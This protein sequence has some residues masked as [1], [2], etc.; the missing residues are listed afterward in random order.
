MNTTFQTPKELFTEPDQTPARFGINQKRSE[1]IDGHIRF[2]ILKWL[3]DPPG[4]STGS[5]QL[6]E[7]CCSISTNVNEVA[8]IAYATGEVLQK[9]KCNSCKPASGIIDVLRNLGRE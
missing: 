4:T 7:R 5:A 1:E 3:T 8:W 9:M 2:H 6:I